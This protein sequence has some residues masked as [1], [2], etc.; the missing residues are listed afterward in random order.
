M[1]HAHFSG[2]HGH[3]FNRLSSS[4]RSHGWSG[5]RWW[6]S[7]GYDDIDTDPRLI[8]SVQS[9]LAGLVGTWVPQTG[10]L[11][12]ATRHAIRTFQSQNSLPVTGHPDTETV[13]QIQ[14]ACSSRQDSPDG[15]DFQDG[16]KSEVAFPS[17]SGC[18]EDRCTSSYISW[19]QTSLNA[20]GSRL[21][22]TGILDRPTIN[23]INKFKQ[24]HG[25][26][27]REY[28][29][30]PLIE[31]ALRKAGAAAPA[32]V[33]RLPC[34]P[35]GRD[36][37]LPLLKKYASDIPA[38]YLLGWIEVESGAK[39]GDL[40][41]I[42]E[43]GYF[44]VHPEESQALGLDHD[45]LSTDPAY[46]VEGGLTL[47][48]KYAS[49]VTRLAAQLGVNAQGDLFWGLAKLQHWIPSAAVRILT[50]M[51]KDGIPIAD[52]SN[53]HNYVYSKSNLG[54]GSFDPR[55]GVN[56]VDHY[57]A[58]VARWRQRLKGGSAS[59]PPANPAVPVSTPKT[60]GSASKSRP[61]ASQ[62]SN[63]IRTIQSVIQNGERNENRLT[64][65]V[66][67][68]RH[69]ERGG[70]PLQSSE[71]PL[72]KEWLHIRSRLVRPALQKLS[73]S[74]STSTAASP[75][76]SPVPAQPAVKPPST[77]SGIEA[78]GDT[79]PLIKCIQGLQDQGRRISFVQRY[80][81]D[82]TRAEVAALRAAG[83][84]VVSCFEEGT[85]THNATQISYFTRVQGQHDARRAFTHAQA[86]GQTADRPVYFAID[87]DAN[88]GQ[89]QAILDYVQ[90][91]SEGYAQ[92]LTDMRSQSK[93]PV[94]YAIGVYGSG[95]VLAWCQAQGIAGWFWQAFAPGW[96]NNRNVW[97]GANVRTSGL[98]QPERCQRR[99]GHLEGWANEGGW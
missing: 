99:F 56:S 83:F 63:D 75:A 89:R 37:L 29:A 42:C 30:S 14:N 58:S 81:R 87:T 65:L 13:A 15:A 49:A 33:R 9:C 95:C 90:G 8:S 47:V 48:R 98:D 11:G 54:F 24:S 78:D 53:I 71:T 20:L 4:G 1:A 69:P 28:Y 39:L 25:V 7:G 91:L 92:Y 6:G 32:P 60:N 77:T 40:T 44:Q 88:A 12:Q 51:R 50:Q 68:G 31:Q 18:N 97:P 35:T 19:I 61:S 82:L 72:V 46:S 57:L 59:T 3:G 64:D 5:R 23:A 38:E 70:Q 93:Q 52:W 41:K 85:K 96:C 76:Q 86:V 66:F 22:I 10:R 43:R 74:A 62:I 36:Q 73:M 21:K 79:T 2:G 16:M 17:P 84:Q 26:P 94:S 34:G 45:R 55:A 27:Q 67:S 80:L